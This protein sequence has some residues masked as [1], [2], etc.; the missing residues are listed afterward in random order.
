MKKKLISSFIMMMV[1]VSSFII[2]AYGASGPGQLETPLTDGVTQDQWVR[3]NDQL[4]EFE[5][6]S[7]LVRYFNPSIVNTTD[8]IYNSLDNQYYIHDEMKR[9]IMDLKDEAD[10]LKDSGATDT[11][12]G[13]EQYVI[14]NTAVKGMKTSAEKMGRSLDYL[15]RPNSSIQS[16]ITQVVKNYTYYANQVMI[17]YNSALANREVLRKVEELSHASLEAQRLNVQQGISTEASLL[18]AQKEV[19]SAQ[20]SLLKLNNTIDSLRRSLCLMTGYFEETVP[21]I[22][23][24]PLLDS[25]AI[26]AIDL[27]TDTAKAIGNNYDLISQRH[28]SSNRTTTG[29]KNKAAEGLVGEQN[30]VIAMH[31]YYQEILQEK[32]A[33]EA[34]CISY[35]RAVLEKEK[36]DYSFQ[37]G[38]LSKIGYLQSQMAYLQAESAKQNAYNSLYLAYDTYCWAVNGIIITSG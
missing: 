11:A 9:Y 29:M 33:Y 10:G 8:T 6:L 3:L 16:N 22:G 12:A 17:S 30:I 36:A 21:A 18:S 2:S 23:G 37:L 35:E 5:E 27:E 26:S 1:L 24:L 15:N 32:N 13:M 38:M 4:I 19:L 31:S 34:A 25:S 28:I 7:D 20:S 14:L